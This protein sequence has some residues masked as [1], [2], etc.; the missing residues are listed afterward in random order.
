M[1]VVQGQLDD[2]DPLVPRRADQAFAL[3]DHERVPDRAPADLEPLGQLFFPQVLAAL[4]FA[5]QDGLAEPVG[6][7]VPK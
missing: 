4:Q 1:Q 2:R 7:V 5:V 3:Q 6:D